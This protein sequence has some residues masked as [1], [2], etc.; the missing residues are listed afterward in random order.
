M[1]CV[2]KGDH[3]IYRKSWRK[4]L[5]YFNHRN[6]IL[7]RLVYWTWS[8]HFVSHDNRPLWPG[9][10]E[11]ERTKIFTYPSSPP[12]PIPSLS[13]SFAATCC[14]FLSSLPTSPVDHTK[15][16]FKLPSPL[17]AL[18]Q[19]SNQTSFPGNPQAT[20]GSRAVGWLQVFACPSILPRPVTVLISSCVADLLQ[21]PLPTLCPHS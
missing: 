16:N 20:L 19:H 2:L 9:K 1:S 5:D 7:E 10:Q 3:T 17:I 6:M 18:F 21:W 8:Q 14:G 11:G 12:N 4:A 13:P 15:L